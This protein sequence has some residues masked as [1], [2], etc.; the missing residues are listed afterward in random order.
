MKLKDLT[1]KKF[2]KLTVIE[3]VENKGIH[4]MWLCE[5][6]CGNKKSIDSSHL[7]Q[8]NVISCGCVGQGKIGQKHHQWTGYGEISGS[9]WATI[10]RSQ[11]HRN[12][13]KKLDFEI[14]I[15]YAWELF[16]KQDRKCSLT[17]KLL[18][19]GKRNFDETTASLDRIDNNKGYI[20]GNVQWVHKDVNRM[21]N[22]FDMD[23][24][25]ETCRLITE[26]N[27]LT[28]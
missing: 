20:E 13:R 11:R 9:R 17:G 12:S 16:L 14:D 4:T 19:F 22:V 18:K 15:K 1:G 8:G 23:Y 10:K 28:T 5:C 7:I 24:F 21:K 6:Q 26:N 3:R 27:K 2:G 25:L